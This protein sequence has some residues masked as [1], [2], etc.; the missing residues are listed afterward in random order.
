M[1]DTARFCDLRG[2]SVDVSPDGIAV[3]TILGRDHVNSLD[4]DDH[5]ELSEIWRRLDDDPDVRAVVIT[6]SGD[7]FSAGG[8]MEMELRMAGRHGSTMRTMHEARRLV[9][10]IVD[11]DTPIVSAIN[12][13]AAGA[14]LATAL[15]ADISVIGEGTVL[16]DGHTRIGIAAGDHAALIWPLLCGMAR[17]KHL[18]LTSERIDGAHAAQIGL[19][20]TAVPNDRVLD[21]AMDVAR[22]LASGPEAALGF[23]KR[24]LNLWLKQALPM[25]EASLGLEMLN[26]LGPDYQ[27]GLDAFREKRAPDFTAGRAKE[28]E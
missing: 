10:N 20:S 1:T 2:L 16:T 18:L 19:V 15:L 23:T 6:G 5:R 13:P 24:A 22:R 17:A 28:S 21:G 8:N 26:V 27:E 9:L 7:Y 11:C 14:G 3:V 25:F 12:G 4:E